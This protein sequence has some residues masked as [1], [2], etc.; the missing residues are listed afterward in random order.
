MPMKKKKKNRKTFSRGKSLILFTFCILTL[1]LVLHF[2]IEDIFLRK[3]GQCTSGV[4]TGDIRVANKRIDYYYFDF[5]ANGKGYQGNSWVTDPT[6]I[7]DTIT[8]VYLPLFPIIN[9]SI[10]GYFEDD[11]QC[12]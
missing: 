6:R 7:G 5:T 8:V 4:I 1:S 10:P 12:E 2:K 3:F 9:R 11:F